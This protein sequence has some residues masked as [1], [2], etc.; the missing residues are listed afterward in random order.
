MLFPHINVCN[1]LLLL[2]QEDSG[3]DNEDEDSDED[4]QCY[5]LCRSKLERF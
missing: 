2:Y 3:D 1:S 4:A 5:W